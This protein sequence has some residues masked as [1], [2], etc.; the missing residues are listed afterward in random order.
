MAKATLE[1][2]VTPD[3]KQETL[4]ETL[5][6]TPT[7]LA[8]PTQRTVTTLAV[9]PERV[10]EDRPWVMAT[11]STPRLSVGGFL[12]LFRLARDERNFSRSLLVAR[13][14]PP[15]AA[16]GR[17]QRQVSRIAKL[18]EEVWP[19]PPPLPLLLLPRQKQKVNSNSNSNNPKEVVTLQRTL[20][21]LGDHH[22][23]QVLSV[24]PSNSTHATSRPFAA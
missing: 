22:R 24:R 21:A 1:A 8:T 5:V 23:R 6:R 7:P 15:A 3:R 20:P 2:L 12:S 16:V 13:R 10:P 11:K 9:A 4:H 14:A 18:M 17:N 19:P